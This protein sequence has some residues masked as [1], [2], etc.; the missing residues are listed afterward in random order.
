MNLIKKVLQSLRG[1]VPLKKYIKRGLKVGK[2][3]L[4]MKGSIIDPAHC[5]HITIGDDVIIAPNVHILAHDA[6]TKTF[7]G[8]TRVADVTI[9]NR[10]FIGAGSIILP[11]V[12]IG[13]DVVIGAG[14]VVNK[15]ISSNSLA[16]GVPAKVISTLDDYLE[17][18][19]AKIK[20]ENTF[21]KNYTLR[22]KA[23][24]AFHKKQM[25]DAVNKFGQL[26]VE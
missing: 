11:G 7:L 6:G 14:S 25:I 2:N 1:E 20:E 3:L 8:Y 9:G 12:N 15:S 4:L 22:N 18:E 26:Y 16:V 10:V 5:W 21:D 23:F 13:D 19:K 17:K 24:S